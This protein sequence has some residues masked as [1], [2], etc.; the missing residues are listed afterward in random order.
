VPEEEALSATEVVVK[1]SAMSE[2][3]AGWMIGKRVRAAQARL[4][5]LVRMEGTLMVFIYPIK[6]VYARVAGGS[7]LDL[8]QLRPSHRRLYAVLL[9]YGHGCWSEPE[10]ALEITHSWRSPRNHRLNS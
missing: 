6:V 10:D 8:R 1:K 3:R 4:E 2:V 7:A 9:E 5:M